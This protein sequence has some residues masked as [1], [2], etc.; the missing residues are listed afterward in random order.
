MK[1]LDCEPLNPNSNILKF[2]V[3]SVFTLETNSYASFGP[4]N[5]DGIFF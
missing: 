1:S 5:T 4:N 3:H 2:C